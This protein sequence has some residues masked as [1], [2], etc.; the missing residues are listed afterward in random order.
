MKIAQEQDDEEAFRKINA[1]IQ[2]EQQQ[3]F[4]RKLNFVTGK[5]RTRSATMIQVEEDNGAITER[6]TQDTV[7][8]SIFSE[9]HEKHYT[10]AGELPYAMALYSRPLDTRQTHLHPKQS[11]TERT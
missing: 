11:W 3:D 6:K 4:W 1:I 7:E 9:V 10:L 2:R 8:Q 5:K